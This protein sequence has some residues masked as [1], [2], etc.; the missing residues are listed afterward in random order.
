MPPGFPASGATNSATAS[1]TTPNTFSAS[2]YVLDGSPDDAAEAG[3]LGGLA[4]FVPHPVRA[5]GWRELPGVIDELAGEVD[6]RQ[7]A[8]TTDAPA[9]YLIVYALQRFRELS[10]ELPGYQFHAVG[11]LNLL[12]RSSWAQRQALLPLY[13]KC[14]APY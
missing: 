6:R 11:C 13:S 8:R 7:Q 10:R 3:F 5:V 9:V 14:E 12:D 1:L 2:F 4:A